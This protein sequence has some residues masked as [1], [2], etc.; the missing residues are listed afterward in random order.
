MNWINDILQFIYS[1]ICSN[2]MKIAHLISSASFKHS[3]A[4]SSRRVLF[5]ICWFT[6]SPLDIWMYDLDWLAVRWR[7]SSIYYAKIEILKWWLLC[8]C[9]YNFFACSSILLGNYLNIATIMLCPAPTLIKHF[10]LYKSNWSQCG[11]GSIFVV[12]DIST[13]LDSDS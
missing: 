4:R 10:S 13:F 7:V 6:Q 8:V 2:E 9:T 11:S 1:L 12:V 5:K 3:S